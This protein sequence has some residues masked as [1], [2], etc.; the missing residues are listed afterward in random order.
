MRRGAFRKPR[1]FA[2]FYFCPL[3]PALFLRHAA[4]QFIAKRR[5]R[6]DLFGKPRHIGKPLRH[7]C[8]FHPYLLIKGG[9]FAAHGFKRG[10]SIDEFRLAAAQIALQAGRIA[11]SSLRTRPC[12]SQLPFQRCGTVHRATRS[13]FQIRNTRAK[14]FAF[15]AQTIAFIRQTLSFLT[16]QR[17]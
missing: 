9:G 15:T 11:A 12:F 3:T 10:L 1:T 4:F 8:T 17:Q 6:S 5:Q 7:G 13:E 16:Q 14:P 2:D